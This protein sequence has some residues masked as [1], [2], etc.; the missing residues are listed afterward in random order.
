MM[1]GTHGLKPPDRY[2][3]RPTLYHNGID[4][5][6]APQLIWKGER[7]AVI[8]CSGHTSWSGIGS[9]EYYATSYCLVRMTHGKFDEPTRFLVRTSN[10][11]LEE[12]INVEKVLREKNPGRKWRRCCTQLIGEGVVLDGE[13]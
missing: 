6:P 13:E 11:K 9:R 5:G 10:E 3:K 12:Y 2:N 8:K 1:E 7:H 4:Y